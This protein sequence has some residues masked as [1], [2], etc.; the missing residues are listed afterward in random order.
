VASR[1]QRQGRRPGGALEGLG[2]G[3]HRLEIRRGKKP[4][5][6][7]RFNVTDDKLLDVKQ[8][9]YGFFEVSVSTRQQCPWP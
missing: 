4:Y 6:T 5:E 7:I 2:T 3:A 9:N 1:R 8:N